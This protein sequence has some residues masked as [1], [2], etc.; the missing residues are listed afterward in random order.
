M[1]YKLTYLFVL[2][3]LNSG[4]AQHPV[5]NEVMFLNESAF[6]NDNGDFYPWVEIYNP[7]SNPVQLSNYFL[8]SNPSI[9]LQWQLPDYWLQPG[10]FYVIFATGFTDELNPSLSGV[11]LVNGQS[12]V[13]LSYL[14]GVV[15]SVI[16]E[17]CVRHNHSLGRSEDGLGAPVVFAQST[18]GFSNLFGQWAPIPPV[19]TTINFS[20]AGG[21]YAEPI[22]LNL[23]SDL[24]GTK[25]HFTI[26]T[27]EF[28]TA[29]N[30]QFET[31]LLLIDRSVEPNVLT[32]FVTTSDFSQFYIPEV[33]ISKSNVI[34]AIAYKDGCPISEVAT[35][36]YF[37]NT[38]GN[39]S[40][41]V[42]VAAIVANPDD[43][44]SDE[45][46]LYVQ[47][48]TQNY[49]QRGAEWERAAHFELYNSNG[50]SV[51]DQKIGIRIHG[52][53]TREASQ[54]SLRLYAKNEYGTG[55]FHA[56][57]FDD[58][59]LQSFKRLLL[60]TTMGDWKPNVFK[61]ELCHHL[62]K[63]LNV[64]YMAGAPTIVFLNGE[65]WGI[66]NLRE[67]QDKY[68]LQ[69][70]HNLNYPEVDII[71]Y[72]I[73]LRA[74]V[75]DGDAFAYN[76]LINF[77]ETNDLSQNEA[78]TEFQELVDV[79]NLIDFLIA[80]LYLANL[81]FPN[82]NY[83]MWKPRQEPGKWRWLFFDCDA[84]MI[85]AN[86]NHLSEY[87]QTNS[88]LQRFPDWSTK[89]GRA[90][91]KNKNFKQRFNARFQQVLQY[92]FAADKVLETISSYQQKFEPL[93]AEHIERWNIPNDINL[94]LQTIAELRVFAIQRPLE[95]QR[96][97]DQYFENPFLVYPNPTNG[98]FS[99]DFLEATGTRSLE[100]FTVQ[101]VLL[102]NYQFN[103]LDENIVFIDSQL[104]P[105][106]YILKLLIGARY[107]SQK[108]VVQ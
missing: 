65:Y 73:N 81:D 34:R 10:D 58:K 35:R 52:G 40:Y 30:E 50:Q 60:R 105:G 86:Y 95:M 51:L 75:E 87:L 91:F 94:W 4:L 90:A 107:Y 72:D 12:K 46:G 32:D 80:H 21:F 54:K 45:S 47:G 79:D 84:C 57:L 97:I 2:L 104:S 53:G 15:V 71:K 22:T 78:Y 20:H 33:K 55:L 92:D 18:P 98:S 66:Q 8:S 49:T 88:S 13:L 44:F 3:L 38:S 6:A 64:D 82:R 28:P 26:N 7:N 67:R 5:I 99:I 24:S 103:N 9:A 36:N 25:I 19:K 27:S 56:Q 39:N 61:D 48:N 43:L 1:R 29:A 108:L 63:D 59:P 16:D 14:S 93:M 17:R 37:I 74:L 102:K 106:I 96:I 70:N 23:S 89:I 85:R 42:H 41:G 68:Y 77:L 11:T 100:I 31:P 62:V 76:D 69:D 101:G 83:G